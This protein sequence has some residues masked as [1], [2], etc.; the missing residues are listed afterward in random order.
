MLLVLQLILSPKLQKSIEV[1]DLK[2]KNYKG[3]IK[4]TP[5]LHEMKKIYN[6][7]LL[8]SHMGKWMK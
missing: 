2:Q 1:S 4:T 8:I 7:F 3:K 6:I 5:K